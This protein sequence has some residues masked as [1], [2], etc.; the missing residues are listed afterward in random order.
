MTHWLLYPSLRPLTDFD[1][2]FITIR[3]S[4]RRKPL[5]LRLALLITVTLKLRWF[6]HRKK[7]VG[8]KSTTLVFTIRTNNTV[9]IAREV[10]SLQKRE[11][12]LAHIT[13]TS[14]FATKKVELCG[15]VEECKI[16]LV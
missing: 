2:K 15:Q 12:T 5:G 10:T 8:Y 16:I 1:S 13:I 14:K 7:K 9:T 3:S 6:E 4:R 11:T